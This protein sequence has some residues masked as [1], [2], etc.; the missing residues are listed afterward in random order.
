[1]II[2]IDGPA[3]SGKSSVAKNLA[4]KIG[5][6]FFDS[7]AMY[8]AVTYGLI[9]EDI[10][11]HNSELLSQFLQNFN[12]SISSEAGEK[13][14]HVNGEDVTQ[15]I[16]SRIVTNRVSEIAAIAEV[17]NSLVHIQRNCAKD[18][19]AVFE[20]RDMG[21]VVF[22]KAQLKVFLIASPR[23]RAERRFN[24]IMAKNSEEA[25]A[26]SLKQVEDDIIRRDHLDSTREHSPLREP[27]N[28][29][30]IDTSNLSIAEVIKKIIDYKDEINK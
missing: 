24:E 16:R 1:M 2:T 21:T 12:Y 3:G 25:K 6:I 26:L 5:Y 28:A 8:R 13:I 22:P 30:V 14:Y 15:H 20:G 27:E 4:E 29:K 19:N 17:R 10:D 9:K 18:V 11:P 7:G 23:V